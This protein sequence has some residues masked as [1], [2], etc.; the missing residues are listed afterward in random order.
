MSE[1]Y[2]NIMAIADTVL[3]EPPTSSSTIVSNN[4]SSSNIQ[5]PKIDL[6]KFDGTL[7]NWISFRDTFISLVHDN[8]NIGRLEKFHYLLICVSGSALTVVKAIPLSAANYDIVWMALIDRY[9]NQRL[10]ATAHLE[11]LF[12]FRP[13]ST[14]SLSSLS[15]FVSTFQE[16]ISAIKVLGVNNLAGFM[17]FFIRSRALD[18]VT[19]NLFESTVSQDSIPVFDVLLKF[20]Q[21]RCKVLENIRS[22]EKLVTHSTKIKNNPSS[23]AVLTN[24]DANATSPGTFSE[25]NHG[26]KFQRSCAYCKQD[27]PIYRCQAF[28]K[29]TVIKRREFASSNKLCFSCMNPSHAVSVCTSKYNCKTCGER[30]NTLLHLK[31]ENKHPQP[32][33]TSNHVITMNQSDSIEPKT[34][35]AGTSYT[36][37]TVV[38]GT[39]C[40]RIQD[41]CGSYHS[42]RV[43]L[44]SGSQI[45]AITS[46]CANRIGLGR[47]KCRTEISGLGQNQVILVKGRTECSFIPGQSIEPAIS[48]KEVHELHHSCQPDLYH[49]V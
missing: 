46:E 16:N 35:F 7:F 2:Y 14:E 18:P 48:C 8:L 33:P 1:F 49:Q 47:Q 44:D 41:R 5:L 19:C 32:G 43:L 29:L 9:D 3:D 13:I 28:S 27:H 31:S 15:A 23:R 10:L 11:K 17:L 36:N 40:V 24:A 45:S 30:H 12:S 34:Q 21:Q 22:S 20:L 6:P 39:A 25:P 42:V 26:R 37:N 38:L 4:N